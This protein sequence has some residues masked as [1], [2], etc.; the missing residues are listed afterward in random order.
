VDILLPGRSAAVDAQLA[1]LIE[2]MARENPGW[3]YRR[4]QGELLGLGIRVGAAGS[5]LAS[6]H[7]SADPRP[8]LYD[9]RIRAQFQMIMSTGEQNPG[10]VSNG[11]RCCIYCRSHAGTIWCLRSRGASALLPF[12]CFDTPQPARV[13]GSVVQRWFA[14][15]RAWASHCGW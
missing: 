4:I 3:G 5:G 15:R 6:A 7:G 8:G 10:F 14:L 1:V 13:T 11:S 12:S 2:R 9:L